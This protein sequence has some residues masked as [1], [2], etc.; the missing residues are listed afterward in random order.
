M[1]RI[2]RLIFGS[3][4]AGASL[5]LVVPAAAAAVELVSIPITGVV[6]DEPGSEVLVAR[7]EV[8]EDLVGLRCTL[9]GETL[10]QRS[11]H[12]GNDLLI[13]LGDET[14]VFTNFEDEGGVRYEF[15]ETGELP[16]VVEVFVRLG[17]DGVSSG[18]FHISIECP[19]V[20]P[21]SSTSTSTTTTSSTSVPA[22]SSTTSST[23][24]V[25]AGPTVEPSLPSSLPSQPP[26]AG[27]DAPE[28][29]VTGPELA[30]TGPAT[31]GLVGV[32]VGL[33]VAG[34]FVLLGGGRR[35]RLSA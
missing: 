21:P 19:D 30:V 23:T 24:T 12:L 25:I 7:A 29:P 9:I 5:V 34:A 22:S 17:P 13:D 11:V 33:L 4:V 3:A 35:R 27:P 32:G 14:F 26:G 20:E 10:N 28:P 1:V 6:R 18:G 2:R 15:T 8:P 31:F 16:A